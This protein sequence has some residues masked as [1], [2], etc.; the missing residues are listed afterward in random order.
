MKGGSY[1]TDDLCTSRMWL[2]SKERRQV[3]QS[4]LSRCGSPDR[5]PMRLRTRELPSGKGS[6]GDGVND[7]SGIGSPAISNSADD[8]WKSLSV[9][10]VGAVYEGV[11]KLGTESNFLFKP[12]YI[13]WVSQE[14]A[15]C[16]QFLHTF[17][18]RAQFFR[19]EVS[20]NARLCAVIQRVN[21]RG[22]PQAG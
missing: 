1:G 13:N 22:R 8:Y 10:T 16:P 21:E 9:P 3:L 19:L 7:Q 17:I 18:D 14:I 11:K 6:S 15:L 20:I 5:G 12:F 4:V 2:H